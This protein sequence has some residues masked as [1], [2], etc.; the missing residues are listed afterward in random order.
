M[1]VRPLDR[2]IDGFE[3]G[4]LL[5]AV[6][7]DAERIAGDS[8][9]VAG[10]G[11]GVAQGA[12]AVEQADGALEVVVALFE[13]FQGTAPECPLGLVAASERQDDGKR[14][15][16]VTEIVAD[17]LAEFGLF[18]GIVEHI[19]DELEGDAEIEAEAFQRLL[20]YLRPASDHRADTAGGREERRGLA[21]DDV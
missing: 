3:E 19:V 15:L 1:S 21:T 5:R 4:P 8:A 20:F 6:R 12:V 7:E 9:V 10:A 13:I 11:D 17:A 14:D 2:E 18:G 16:A